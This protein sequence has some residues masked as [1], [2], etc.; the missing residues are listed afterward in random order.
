MKL[1]LAEQK[2]RWR[3]AVLSTIAVVTTLVVSTAPA[4][5]GGPSKPFDAAWTM[6]NGCDGSNCTFVTEADRSGVLR[7]TGNFE[8]H[9]DHTWGQNGGVVQTVNTRG[10]QDAVDVTVTFDVTTVSLLP[11]EKAETG[12]GQ[13]SLFATAFVADR[14]GTVSIQGLVF[15]TIAEFI[16]VQA[17]AL[18]G[19]LPNDVESTE[20]EPGTY[21]LTLRLETEDGSRLPSHKVIV[22][23]WLSGHGDVDG[24]TPF[25]Y[26]MVATVTS[27]SL[28]P[29]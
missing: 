6:E 17:D 24:A 16:V 27:I 15:E 5:A 14:D 9:P 1:R 8:A 26:E 19:I 25:S 4:H 13:M 3:A 23:A 11:P 10:P 20:Q 7:I 18:P 22:R 2:S 29:A 28:T 21:T 12:G